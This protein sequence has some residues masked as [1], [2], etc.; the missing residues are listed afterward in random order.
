ME[1]THG[2]QGTP[3]PLWSGEHAGQGTASREAALGTD[4]NEA[5]P[6]LERCQSS[7]GLLEKQMSRGYM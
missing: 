6:E 5:G 7:T 4:S 3:A 1:C 2:E